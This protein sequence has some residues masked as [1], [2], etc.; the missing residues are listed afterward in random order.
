MT[1]SEYDEILRSIGNM[2]ESISAQTPMS[3]DQVICVIK[4]IT[5]KIMEYAALCASQGAGVPATMFDAEIKNTMRNLP[6]IIKEIC[7]E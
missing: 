4:Y 3:S 1:L 7:D 2:V 5:Q 6:D